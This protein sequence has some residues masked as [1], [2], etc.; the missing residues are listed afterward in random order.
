MSRID[1]TEPADVDGLDD[2]SLETCFLYRCKNGADRAMDSV[3]MRR[4][5]ARV[6]MR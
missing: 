3:T 4:L 5:H 2:A 1:L 6:T